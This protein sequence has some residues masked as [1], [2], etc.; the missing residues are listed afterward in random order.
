MICFRYIIV[1]TL[2]KVDKYNNN[3]N[4]N[5]K[6][7]FFSSARDMQAKVRFSVG[8]G[9]SID[10]T[11]HTISFINSISLLILKSDISLCSLVIS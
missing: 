10:L 7:N 8:P 11:V 5:N 9:P 2:H 1:N 6:H 4:N 3:M